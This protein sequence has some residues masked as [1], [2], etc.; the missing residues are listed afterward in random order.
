[1]ST[2]IED[3]IKAAKTCGSRVMKSKVSGIEVI[4]RSLTRKEMR[5]LQRKVADKTDSL[6]KDKERL[7]EAELLR[8]KEEGEEAIVFR[9]VLSPNL[10]SELD[11][12]GLPAAFVPN[13]A[14]YILSASGFGEEITPPEEL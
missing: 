10:E 5:D 1:M 13:V 2:S 14:E 12:L 11:L 8:L 9:G 6:R 3:K 7:S 4:Y